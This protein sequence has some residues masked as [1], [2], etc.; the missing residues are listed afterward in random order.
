[1]PNYLDP[2]SWPSFRD[3]LE[4]ELSDL[5][6]DELRF[7]GASTLYIVLDTET[8]RDHSGV[9]G[10]TR[11]GLAFE[12]EQE[13]QPRWQGPAPGI[14]LTVSDLPLCEAAAQYISAIAL[15]EV[16]HILANPVPEGFFN[17]PQYAVITQAFREVYAESPPSEN[18]V[19]SLN[20]EIVAHQIS[21]HGAAFVR[22]LIHLMRRAERSGWIFDRSDLANWPVIG[23]TS[24]EGYEVLLSS[25]LG[26][27]KNR[28]LTDLRTKEADWIFLAEYASHKQQIIDQWVDSELRFAEAYEKRKGTVLHETAAVN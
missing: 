2:K 20:A 15:H 1:M 4:L 25:D 6:R 7:M 13:L 19:E 3:S 5:L 16:S 26:S 14:F 24:P 17:T 27:F 12:Y 11:S 23:F 8:P 21:V 22:P 28:P 10:Y 9:R 18:P